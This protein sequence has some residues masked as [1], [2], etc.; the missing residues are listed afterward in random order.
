[1]RTVL[2]LNLNRSR[3]ESPSLR[4]KMSYTKVVANGGRS[5]FDVGA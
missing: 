2:L 1:M 4:Y 5:L 3:P